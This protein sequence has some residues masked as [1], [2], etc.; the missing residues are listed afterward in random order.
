MGMGD[1]RERHSTPGIHMEPAE[2]AAQPPRVGSD[3]GGVGG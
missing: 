1:D 3:E 2:F